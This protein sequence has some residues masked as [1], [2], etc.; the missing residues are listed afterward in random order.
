MPTLKEATGIE[1]ILAPARF[2]FSAPTGVPAEIRAVL[3]RE[4][5]RAVADS[6]IA[7]KL[8]GAGLDVVSLP[9]ARMGEMIRTETIYNAS[10]VKR[11]GFK[12]A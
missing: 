12:L 7:A 2:G 9:A 4:I 8:A 1:G 10:T 3:E 11:L 6:Q 5:R